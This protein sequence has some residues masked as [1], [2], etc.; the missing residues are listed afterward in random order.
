MS[1]AITLLHVI[2]IVPCSPTRPAPRRHPHSFDRELFADRQSIHFHIKGD[3]G[4]HLGSAI[5]LNNGTT[6][7]I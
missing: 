6:R 1:V 4:S 5:S 3:A 2:A 7:F